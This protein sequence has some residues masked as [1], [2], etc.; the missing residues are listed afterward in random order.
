M[1]I[2]PRELNLLVATLAVVLLAGTYL[3][4]EPSL[5]EWAEFRERRESL[6]TRID[7]ARRL[8]DS[9]PAVEAR[10]DEFRQGLPV[11]P[12][13]RKVEADLLLGLERMAGEHNLVLTRREAAAEREAGDLFETSITCYWEG[14]LSALVRFLFAQQSQG[15]VSDVRQLSIQPSSGRGDPPGHL[16]GTFTMDYAYRR[17]SGSTENPPADAPAPAAVTEQP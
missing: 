11:Y 1:K 15:V 7:Q 4:M 6:Q 17:E 8:L 16:R 10:L 2:A 5:Q 9:R 3:A 13:G 14:D 12:A